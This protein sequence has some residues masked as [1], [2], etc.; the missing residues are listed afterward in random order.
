[1]T[2]QQ[3]KILEDDGERLIPEYHKGK[4]IYGEHMGRYLSALGAVSDEVVLDIACGSGYGTKLLA[5]KAKYVYGVDIDSKAVE[6]AR[7]N[8]K[9]SNAEYKLGDGTRIPLEENSVDT[10]ISME[11]IEHIEDQDTFLAE[12]KRV[13]RNKGK[14]ILST[15]N[16]KEYPKGNHFHVKEHNKKTLSKLLKKYF[17]NVEFYY[18]TDEIAATIISEKRLNKEFSEKNWTVNKVNP[19]SENNAIY[20]IVS[21][22]DGEPYKVRENTMLA[23]FYS[24]HQVLK[25]WNRE[26]ELWEWTQVLEKRVKELEELNTSLLT[27]KKT[28]LA[29]GLRKIKSKARSVSNGSKK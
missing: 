2:K 29:R 9:A 7:R 22:S 28:L 3:N 21:C 27:D 24:Y 14:L 13:L 16:D 1:M 20:F 23:E 19:L 12:I 4:I 26:K 18:Q 17:K 5:S 8:F 10:V 25:T 15:P 11:T 6:Y